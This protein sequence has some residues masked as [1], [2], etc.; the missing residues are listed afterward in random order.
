M[1]FLFFNLFLNSVFIG[2]GYSFN[3]HFFIMGIIGVCIATILLIW[4]RLEI[5]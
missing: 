3:H 5:K 1:N 4:K 2:Y